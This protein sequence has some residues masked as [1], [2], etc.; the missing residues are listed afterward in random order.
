[1]GAV[2]RLVEQEF[3]APGDHGLAESDED[4]QQILQVHQQRAAIVERHHV[5][6][7]IGLQRGEFV[8]LVQHHVGDDVALQLDHHAKAVAVGFVAQVGDAFDLLVAHQFCD[9]LDHRGLVHLIGNFRDDDRFAVFSR[10]LDRDLAAHHDGAA[11]GK[12]GLADAGAAEDDA[13]GREI[14][15]GNDLV[16]VLD[17][18]R[19][20]VDQ[21]DAGIDDFAEIVRRDVGRHA[22]G[23]AA[24]AIDQQVGKL[25]RQHA[26]FAERAV[27]VVLVVDRVLVE[28]VEQRLRDL[29][30]ARFRVSHRGGGIA[31]DRT[32]IALPVDQRHPHRE[33]L[34]HADHRVID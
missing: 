32:E 1:M 6:A 19:G 28:I 25:G 7:E 16:E 30:Q 23:D 5:A 13:A 24:A 18:Q 31:V 9:A 26:R 20:I 21:R 12:V 10:G 2:A 29:G 33:G 15:A 3:G 27:V 14:R 34:R 8:E 4:P 17:G 11:A 22:D